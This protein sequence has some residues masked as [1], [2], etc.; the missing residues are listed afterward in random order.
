MYDMYRHDLLWDMK[1]QQYE[2]L[3]GVC[4]QID[5]NFYILQLLIR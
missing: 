2:M 5:G 1:N 4:L 3:G